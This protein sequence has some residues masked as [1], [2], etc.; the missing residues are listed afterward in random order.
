MPKLIYDVDEIEASGEGMVNDSGNIYI[1][2]KHRGMKVHWILLND[3]IEEV[4][5][6]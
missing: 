3:D 1:S 5:K 6:L 4:M 2:R